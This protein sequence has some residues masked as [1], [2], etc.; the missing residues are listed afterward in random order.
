MRIRSRAPLRLGIAGGGTDVSPYSDEYGGSVLNATIDMY[1]HA[2]IDTDVAS[3]KVIFEAKDLQQTDFL[4]S[5][6]LE[7][8]TIGLRLHRATYIRVMNDFNLGKF[9]SLR[10]TTQCDAP[11]GSG[12]GSSSTLVVAMLEAYRQLLGLPLGE[13]DVARLAFEIERTDCGLEGGKQDQYAAAFGGFNFIEFY[14]QDRVIVNPLRIRRYIINELEA[15]LILFFTGASRDS[16]KIIR[17]QVQTLKGTNETA[18][19]AMHRVKKSAYRIK[20]LILKADIEGVSEVFRESWEYKKATSAAI[21]NSMIDEIERKILSAGA[22]AMK[23]SGAGGGG[24]MMIFVDPERKLD[25]ERTLQD[26]DGTVY[27][28]KFVDEGANSWTI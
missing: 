1:A 14:A 9:I 24:F 21:S 26:F 6:D 17:D 12:L 25:I 13:Y 15:S 11:P 10:M 22:K 5:A 20:E 3:E 27:K 28:F 4:T 7:D 18:L 8:C 16:A 19:D 23:V 2:F